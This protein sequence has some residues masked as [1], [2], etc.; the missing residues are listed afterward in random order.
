LEHLEGRA[1]DFFISADGTYH[2]PSLIR[3][4][5]VRVSGIQQFKV[6]QESE[7]SV[8]VS[9]VPDRDFSPNTTETLTEI[10]KGTLGNNTDVRVEIVG[11]IPR[12]PSGKLQAIVS[13][14]RRDS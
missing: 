11:E 3:N 7:T 12:D 6:V 1:Y 9:I 4:Q 10:M 14:V 5:I 8:T 13:K 2:S